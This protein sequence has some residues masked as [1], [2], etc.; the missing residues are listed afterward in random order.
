MIKINNDCVSKCLLHC[1]KQTESKYVEALAHSDGST[2]HSILVMW[3]ILEMKKIFV[4]L[5]CQK[6]CITLF[7]DLFFFASECHRMVL[8]LF[9]NQ[10]CDA[11]TCLVV[12]V[13]DLPPLPPK[14]KNV[15]ICVFTH[16]NMI[17]LLQNVM[18]L[19]F[20]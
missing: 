12:T 15:R 14:S 18:N 3:K 5:F 19:M 8:G 17:L 11:V 1:L 2:K 13:L 9:S 20:S 6:F 16:S 4:F 7:T 10:F